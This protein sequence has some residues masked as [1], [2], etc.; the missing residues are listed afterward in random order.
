[1]DEL[2]EGDLKGL[3]VGGGGGGVDGE[4]ADR[5]QVEKLVDSQR[6][7]ALNERVDR[8]SEKVHSKMWTA[9][10]C[11]PWTAFSSCR[12]AARAGGAT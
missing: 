6:M 9:P 11:S 4:G 1:M 10:R 3:G 7:R 8:L 5:T 12:T 2:G